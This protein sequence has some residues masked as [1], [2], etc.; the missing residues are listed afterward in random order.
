MP[1]G[2]QRCQILSMLQT[3]CAREFLFFT[4]FCNRLSIDC[5]F[6]LKYGS[7]GDKGGERYWKIPPRLLFMC[8]IIKPIAWSR[9][10]DEKRSAYRRF[11]TEETSRK[12]HVPNLVIFPL[13]KSNGFY[14]ITLNIYFSIHFHISIIS[15]ISSKI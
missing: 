14:T 10:A 2:K 9:F 11:G 8:V 12:F 13:I 5:R 15:N 1:C 3:F 4:F 6:C 7:V